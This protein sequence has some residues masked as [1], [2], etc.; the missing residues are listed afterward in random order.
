MTIP[1]IVYV[2]DTGVARLSRYDPRSGTT[3]LQIEAVS[4]ASADQRKG[5]CGR[6]RD[7]I[8]VRLYDEQS[9]AARPAFTDPEIKR[10]GLAGVI[11]RMKSL[12]LGDVEDFPFLDPPQPKAIAEGYRVLEELGRPRRGARADAARRTARALPGGPAHRADDSGRRRVRVPPRDPR[13]RRGAQPPG[14]ARA[15]ARAAAEGRRAAPALP[16]RALRL[17]RPASLVGVRQAR[18]SAR[19]RRT[20]GASAR[21]T[22]SPSCGCANGA[23]SSAS[24]RRSCASCASTRAGRP[25][26]RG[27]SL[28]RA[29]LTGLLSKVGPGIRSSALTS[30]RSRRAS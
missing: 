28:H 17:H 6:V 11:L 12:G 26:G 10:T 8:C 21:T 9:F 13:R 1:G 4:Q 25:D 23:T 18:P 5:R 15:A 24:S 14:P 16:R 7:G 22:S 20:C 30:A 2:V 19:G 27:G 29:L 3:R